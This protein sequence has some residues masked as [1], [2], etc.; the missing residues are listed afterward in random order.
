MLVSFLHDVGV[1]I[2][3]GADLGV[4][5]A[6]RDGNAVHTVEVE[7]GGHSV[8]E[9]VGVDVGEAVAFAEPVQPCG[10]AV[11]VHGLAV[12]LGEYKAL[13]LVVLPQAKPFLILP[14][15]IFAKEFH[16]L[17]REGDKAV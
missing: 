16:G 11:R 10:R 2:G 12:V 14:C 15:P 5:Q 1:N 17:E 8:P 9:C 7:H 4:V 6:F 13:V 3:G